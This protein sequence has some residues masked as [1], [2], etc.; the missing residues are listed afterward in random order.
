MH[1]PGICET[2]S[3]LTFNMNSGGLDIIQVLVLLILTIVE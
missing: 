1:V 2:G 3:N